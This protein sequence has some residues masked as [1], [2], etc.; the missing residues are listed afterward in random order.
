MCQGVHLSAE[1]VHQGSRA[2]HIESRHT[3][4]QMVSP[5]SPTFVGHQGLG[6]SLLV[7]QQHVPA[8]VQWPA[9]LAVCAASI[10]LRAVLQHY[11]A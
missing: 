5:G 10:N 9:P 6:T 3:L 7:T 2:E 8:F 11:A 4:A 1:Y